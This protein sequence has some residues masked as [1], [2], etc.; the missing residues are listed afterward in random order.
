LVRSTD[1][2]Y[3]Y[4]QDLA[5]ERKPVYSFLKLA[6]QTGYRRDG[7]GYVK[8]SLPPLEFTYSEPIIDERVWEVDRQSLE[9][10]PQG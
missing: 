4:S 7:A 2:T 1:L 8:K 9:N 6:T 10:L 5:D 3:T